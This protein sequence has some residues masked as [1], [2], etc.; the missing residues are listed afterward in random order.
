MIVR[1]C[2]YIDLR[3]NFV[4]V[5]RRRAEEILSTWMLAA[6]LTH[7]ELVEILNRYDSPS[8]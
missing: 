2:D 1:A 5:D 6:D 4:R 8:T 7:L 3:S